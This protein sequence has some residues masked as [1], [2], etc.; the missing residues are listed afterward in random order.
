M[1]K[2]AVNSCYLKKLHRKLYDD[3]MSSDT[4]T[5]LILSFYLYTC[6][7]YMLLTKIL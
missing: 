2:L 1:S 7:C 3:K 5:T 4:P 6:Y